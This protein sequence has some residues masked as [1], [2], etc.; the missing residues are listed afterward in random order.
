MN[1][2]SADFLVIG[3]GIAGASVAAHLASSRGV[4]VLEMEEQPGYHTTGRSAA[5][6]EPNYGPRASRALTRAARSFFYSPPEGFVAAPLV[7]PRPTLFLMPSGQENAAEALLATSHGIAAITIAEA[8]SMHPLL[9][10]NYAKACYLDTTTADIDVDLLHQGFLRLFKARG[11]TLVCDAKVAQMKRHNGVWRVSTAKGE[12]AAKTIINAAGAWADQVAGLAGARPVGLVPKRR[13]IAVV[14]PPQDNGVMSWPLV[15]DTG[16][17]WYCKPS[18]GKLL[19]S[20]ADTTPAE[21]HDAFAEDEM[22]AVGIERCQEALDIDVT[23]IERS[24]AG[25]RTFAPDGEPVCGYDPEIEGFFW[26]A[27]QGG[28]GI[29]SSPGLSRYA[30]ALAERRALPADLA[31]QGMGENDLV[32]GRFFA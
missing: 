5:M 19:M 26:L 13:S 2:S 14:P 16:E 7:S 8:R 10:E 25:L 24:W 11:G 27:G 29:Q 6:Y 22:L 23:R 32:P 4:V 17:T 9:R 30:A 1:S 18:G 21:P 12:F 28:Y 20:P 15:T 3:A 31:A